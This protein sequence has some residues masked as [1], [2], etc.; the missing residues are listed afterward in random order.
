MAD[1]LGGKFDPRVYAKAF[2]L[3]TGMEVAGAVAGGE[4][5]LFAKET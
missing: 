4:Q 5:F 2:P 3:Y 1:M